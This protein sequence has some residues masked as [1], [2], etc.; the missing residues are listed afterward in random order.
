MPAVSNPY[1]L[2]GKTNGAAPNGNACFICTIPP[3]SFGLLALLADADQ[4]ERITQGTFALTFDA[5]PT[6]CAT[7]AMGSVDK[8][9]A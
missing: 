1:R 2:T 9:S 5:C 3:T 6:I 8:L 7:G 4:A